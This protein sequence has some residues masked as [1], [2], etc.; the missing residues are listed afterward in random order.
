MKNLY[1]KIL[2]RVAL[3]RANRRLRTV[4]LQY[5]GC[6]GAMNTTSWPPTAG[7]SVGYL[8]TG[9]TTIRWGSEGLLQS[10]K[11]SSGWYA[12]LRFN[13]RTLVDNIKLP[14]G[15]GVTST[16]VQIVDG[17]QWELT[18]REDNTMTPPQV[19]DSVTIVDAG[20]LIGGA[21]ASTILTYTAVVE[22]SGF[23]TSP[24]QAGERTLTVSNL[25]LVDS[26]TGAAQTAN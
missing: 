13:Q 15:S 26:Q 24:K 4:K 8:A 17:Q 25:L 1:Y 10:P 18:V 11:P 3:W 9:I 5:P 20:G 22:G 23:D 6:E 14:N 12:V 21:T 16:R 7:T 19:G 2:L